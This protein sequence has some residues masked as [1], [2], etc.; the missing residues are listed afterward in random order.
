MLGTQ[1]R[2]PDTCPAFMCMCSSNTMATQGSS[3]ASPNLQ[4]SL[5]QIYTRRRR[6]DCIYFRKVGCQ[7]RG[8]P[9]ERPEQ[10]CPPPPPKARQGWPW[11]FPTEVANISW[12]HL[13]CECLFPKM[14]P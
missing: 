14:H 1:G 11:S 12:N 4:V 2:V 6:R 7:E 8:Q 3:T 10:C 5:P 9:E 13:S